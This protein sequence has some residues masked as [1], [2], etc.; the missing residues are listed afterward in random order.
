ML[1]EKRVSNRERVASKL[2]SGP[3]P[4]SPIFTSPD[5]Y[6]Y[7]KGCVLMGDKWSHAMSWVQLSCGGHWVDRLKKKKT[8]RFR[9]ELHIWVTNWRVPGLCF[10]ACGHHYSVEWFHN[11]KF[12]RMIS[13]L[14][15]FHE[16]PR[17]SSPWQ[18]LLF[19]CKTFKIWNYMLYFP[20]KQRPLQFGFR[21]QEESFTVMQWPPRQMEESSTVMW[22]PPRQI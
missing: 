19:L 18:N 10:W 2:G 21:Y 3:V 13:G 11:V 1:R 5:V 17:L 4:K 8:L 6:P 7:S 22:W 15:I 16:S 20:I 14:L 9:G 12:P